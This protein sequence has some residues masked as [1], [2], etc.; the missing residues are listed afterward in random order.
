MDYF[1]MTKCYLNVCPK[2]TGL[3]N[4]HVKPL[5]A[6]TPTVHEFSIHKHGSAHVLNAITVRGEPC[7]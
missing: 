4:A 6:P 3:Y 5:E 2:N 7:V 1:I